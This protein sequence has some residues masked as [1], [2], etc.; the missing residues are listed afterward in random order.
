MK[1]VLNGEAT[2]FDGDSLT[3]RGILAAKGWSFPLIVVKI[4]GKLVPRGEWDAAVAV[5]GDEV[6]AIHLVSGG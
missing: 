1:I 5:D 2:S 3:V 4:N 6:E